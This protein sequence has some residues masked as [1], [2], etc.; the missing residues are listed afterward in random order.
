MSQRSADF[1]RAK[2]ANVKSAIST[3]KSQLTPRQ[4]HQQLAAIPQLDTLPPTT[5]ELSRLISQLPNKT[6]PL[7]YIHTSVVKAC[8]D[9]FAPL[10]TKL[11]NL[12][13]SEGRFPGQFK[14]AQVTPLLKKVGL[15]VSDPANYRPI[16]NLNTI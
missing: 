8:S 9:V 11:A 7:D 15:D 13:F 5:V 10:I 6:S 4:Q 16:S 3:M 14:L 1:F 12:S 2:V